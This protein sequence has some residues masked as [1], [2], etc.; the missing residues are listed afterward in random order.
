MNPFFAQTTA[1]AT[2][3]AEAESWVGTPFVPFHNAKG[4]GVDCVQ[5]A[6]QLMCAC[7]VIEGYDFGHYSLDFAAHT[8]RSMINEWLGANAERFLFLAA[9]E[10]PIAGDVVTFSVG[11]A[12]GHVG[13][14]LNGADFIHSIQGRKVRVSQ[15]GDSTWRSASSTAMRTASDLS[16]NTSRK[17][18]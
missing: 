14:M 16:V 13:V 11:G 9:N 1:L 8:G 10:T 17:A 2:L 18:F 6:A 3:L 15:L 7:G 4:V 12:V 5:L